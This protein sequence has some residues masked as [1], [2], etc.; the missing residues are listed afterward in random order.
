MF[1]LDDKGVVERVMTVQQDLLVARQLEQHVGN[2]AFLIQIKDG[3]VEGG[4]KVAK[5]IPVN[6]AIVKMAGVHLRHLFLIGLLADGRR[7]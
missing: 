2:A 7:Y 3:V 1:A 4:H 6:G 5:A